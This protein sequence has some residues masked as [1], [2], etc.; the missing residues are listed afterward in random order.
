MEYYESRP[1]QI[2]MMDACARTI[3]EGG[4]LMAEAGT[5]TGKTFAYLVPIIISGKKTI[6]ST[7]T[8]NLQEQLAHKDLKFLSS[9]VEVDYAVAKGRGNYLCLRRL[10]A[11]RHESDEEERQYRA[12]LQWASETT[13]GDVEDYGVMRFSLWDRISSDTDA[14]KWNKCGYYG[15]CFY[16]LSA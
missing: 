12:L 13:N 3:E 15:Q 5:G 1:C 8:I 4:I 16:F 14:C 9:I 10:N 6:V 7:R 11:F 2:E